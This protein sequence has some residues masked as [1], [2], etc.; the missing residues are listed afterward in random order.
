MHVIFLVA[1]KKI[2]LSSKRPVISL[3]S[4]KMGRKSL[5]FMYQ[6]AHWLDS[7][8]NFTLKIHALLSHGEKAEQGVRSMYVLSGKKK[9]R[10]GSLLI[11]E[12]D[13]TG[14]HH[15]WETLCIC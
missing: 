3:Y 1:K 2:I 4:R 6:N 14:I 7:S 9:K 8:Y 5:S 13:L 11:S 12:P 15:V 10:C